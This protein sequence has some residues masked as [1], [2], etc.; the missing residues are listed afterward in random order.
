M[1]TTRVRAI[2]SHEEFKNA[3]DVDHLVVLDCYATWCGPCRAIAPKIDQFSIAHTDADFYKVDV[4]QVASV[5]SDLGVRAMPTFCLFKKGE[6]IAEI[7]GANPA[8]IQAAIE[9]N[10]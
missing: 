6:K 8:A 3:I 4:D 1:A 5:A 9:K 7:V 10:K 2:N